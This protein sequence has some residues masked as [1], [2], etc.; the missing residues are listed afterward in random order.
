[1]FSV[2]LV[3]N[4]WGFVVKKPPL[5]SRNPSS[6]WGYISVPTWTSQF[7]KPTIK[8]LIGQLDPEAQ[9]FFK[10]LRQSLV[11]TLAKKPKLDWMGVTWHWCEITT[12]D[13][14]G[15]LIAVHLVPDPHNPRVGVTLSTA[16]FEGT[17]PSKL[18]KY[19]HA[20]LSTATAIG[21]QTWCEWSIG[22]QEAVDAIKELLSLV[23]GD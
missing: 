11:N 20:G 10:D 7:D 4:L 5:G 12:L 14:G 2:C 3:P 23:Q 22:S 13:A 8:E 1:M 15:M 9:V 17:P 6:I 21:H 18:P 19:L 16:F